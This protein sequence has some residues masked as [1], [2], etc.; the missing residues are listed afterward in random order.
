ML[1]VSNYHYIRQSFKANYPSIFGLTPNAFKKQLC[2]F[3]NKAD[4]ISS[5]DLISNE[6][7]ILNSK[8][9]YFFITFDDGLK[10]QYELALPIL[11]ELHIPTMLFVNTRNYEEKKVSTVHKIH[12]LRSILSSKDFLKILNSQVSINILANTDYKKATSIYIYDDLETASLKYFLNFKMKNFVQEELIKPIFNTYFDEDK[13]LAALYLNEKE[14]LHLAQKGYLGSHTHNHYPLG[15]LKDEEIEFELK[16]SKSYLEN[17]TDTLIEMV[18]YPYG[19][20]ESS[21]SKVAQIAKTIGYKYG[22]TTS[23]GTNT[24]KDDKLLLNRFDCNDLPGGKK[25]NDL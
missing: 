23:R 13:V 2:N 6:I 25:S 24:I 16:N 9:N 14:I 1:T 4:F 21:T 17:L 8:N 5:A 11:D 19:T 18:S 10:E 22:F 20:P 12:L 15:F 3:K 7:E